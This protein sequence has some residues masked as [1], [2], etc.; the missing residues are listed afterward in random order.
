MTLANFN[1]ISKR[2]KA[3]YHTKANVIKRGLLLSFGSS[4]IVRK[5]TA[6]SPSRTRG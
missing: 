6:Q 4:L 2:I 5:S 1:A 3:L